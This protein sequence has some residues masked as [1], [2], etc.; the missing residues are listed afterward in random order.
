MPD[1]H[2]KTISF[3]RDDPLDSSVIDAA[4]GEMLYEI[5]TAHRK[6]QHDTTTIRDARR[7]EEVAATW[8]HRAVRYDTITIRG[9]ISKLS[10]W[11]SKRGVFSRCAY[12]DIC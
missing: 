6:L 1:S 3:L 2:G 5:S 8:E 11:L 4:S 9:E 10:D 7:F 12:M